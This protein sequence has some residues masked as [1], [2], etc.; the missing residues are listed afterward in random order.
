MYIVVHC[1]ITYIVG[2]VQNLDSRIWDSGKMNG[3]TVTSKMLSV[4][5]SR[6]IIGGNIWEKTS[7][8][9]GQFSVIITLGS[10]FNCS[11]FAIKKNVKFIWIALPVVLALALEL[12]L[13][14]EVFYDRCQAVAKLQWKM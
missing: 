3:K 12:I 11:S 6:I 7:T 1:E 14:L 10:W 13:M 8:K 2:V 9:Q 5:L 4:I